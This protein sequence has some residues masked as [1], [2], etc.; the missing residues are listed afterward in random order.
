MGEET[1]LKTVKEGSATTMGRERGCNGV[2][3]ARR[4]WYAGSSTV[5]QRRCCVRRPVMRQREALRGFFLL[6]NTGGMV[7]TERQSGGDGDGPV[8]RVLDLR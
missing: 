5:R 6:E 3:A 4:R 8:P 2:E 7:A 1:S